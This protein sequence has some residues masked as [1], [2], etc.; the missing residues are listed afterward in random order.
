[1]NEEFDLPVVS[2]KLLFFIGFDLNN[3]DIA[4][5]IETSY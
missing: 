5:N 1:M 3:F 2:A 4:S